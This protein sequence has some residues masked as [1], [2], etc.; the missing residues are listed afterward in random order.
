MA[1][2]KDTNKWRHSEAKKLLY[3]DI[4]A[5][6]IPVDEKEMDA[7]AVYQH[8]STDP[9]FL[10][11]DFHDKKLFPGRL[12]RLREK[13]QGKDSRMERD[14]KALAGDRMMFPKPTTDF[15]G[16]TRWADSE[17]KKLLLKDIDNNLHLTLTKKKLWK[18]KPECQE[19]DLDIF[20]GRVYQE[21]KAR[22]FQAYVKHK[23]KEKE[24]A[25][26]EER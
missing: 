1:R 12:K 4:I 24:S 23:R 7:A 19:I 5:G 2:K 17:A 6:I 8:Y 3:A 21:I 20:R 10:L 9:N 15:R 22:K 14:A 26:D 18:S 16:T 13:I 25:G 11:S